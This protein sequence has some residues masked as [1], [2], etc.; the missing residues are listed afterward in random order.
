MPQNY[1]NKLKLWS[2]EDRPREKLMQ[3]GKKELSNAELLGIVIGSGSR[4]ENAVE[5]ANRIL[6][7][8]D[9]NLNQLAKMSIEEL[10]QFE[11]IGTAKAIA[12]T[13]ALE[14]SLRRASTPIIS[15]P[16]IRCSKDAYDILK[17]DLCDLPH[18]AFMILLLN[19]A[20]RVLNK[21]TISTGGLTSTVVDVRKIFRKVLLQPYTSAIILA[22][23][24]PSENPKPSKADLKITQKI[25]AAGKN[26]DIE[27]L[28]HIIVLSE[29][30]TS[31]A[32]QGLM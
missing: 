27:V 7:Y 2:V 13:A 5:L 22:H 25:R 16:E 18:E 20:N 32:D 6:N 14:L 24:H 3:K 9:Q 17:A 30:Y 23:N 11:G 15:K 1:S 29:H 10:Q 26:L 4:H 8:N 19:Q 12:I 21:F 31:L 28:D